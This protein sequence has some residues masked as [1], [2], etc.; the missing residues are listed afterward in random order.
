[1]ALICSIAYDLNRNLGGAYREIL[2]RLKPEDHCVFLDH[3]ACWTTRDWYKQI[4]QAI[5][6]YP[7]A[8]LFGAVTNRI[9]NK[10]Q[11]VAGAPAGHDMA[12]HRIFG[13]ALQDKHGSEALDV[14]DGHVL[15]GVVL[16]IPAAARAGLKIPDGFFGVDN[17]MHRA[18]KRAGK[19]VYL[20]RGL[21]VQHWY[22][23]DGVGHASAPKAARTR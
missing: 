20:L 13:K 1:M 17:E 22:R 14:T 21:Y 9:G 16:C 6:R 5:E 3:D 15:S 18:V 11:V 7:D 12:A 8:G 10:D 23:G 19:R 2:E 4:L